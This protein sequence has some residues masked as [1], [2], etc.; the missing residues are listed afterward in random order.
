MARPTQHVSAND[1][2]PLIDFIK[3]DLDLINLRIGFR[4]RSIKTFSGKAYFEHLGYD[5][6]IVIDRDSMD[7]GFILAHE[8]RHVWQSHTGIYYAKWRKAIC[9]LYWRDRY[10]T[11]AQEM[12]R[13]ASANNAAAS[14]AYEALPWE[15]DA[16]TYAK[17]LYARI[18]KEHGFLMPYF[19]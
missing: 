1:Y 15:K 2:Q 3:A 18:K 6:L 10:I 7:I 16:D 19:E 14:I 5:G 4:F 17:R 13:L 12:N 8:L 11:T 9:K